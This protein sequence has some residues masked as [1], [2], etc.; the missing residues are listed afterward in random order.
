MSLPHLT[1][2]CDFCVV[3]GGLSGLCAA[4]AA[5]RGGSKVVIIQDRPMF[6][7]RQTSPCLNQTPKP[8]IM[9]PEY[10]S[11]SLICSR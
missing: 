1:H 7:K 2:E 11:D 3:G 8:C 4:I 6:G 10:V 5:A 9:E